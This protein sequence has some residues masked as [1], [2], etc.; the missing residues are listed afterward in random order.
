VLLSI[1]DLEP[2]RAYVEEE[3]VPL[4]PAPEAGLVRKLLRKGRSLARH[5]SRLPRLVFR[6]RRVASAVG[7]I[8][9]APPD[10][11]T[12][13]KGE[14]GVSKRIAWSGPIPL[15]QVKAIGCALGGTVNDVLLTAASGALRR[16]LQGH[17]ESADGI[18][19]H[20]AVPVN[21]RA[22]GTEGQLGNRVG[23][24]FAPLPVGVADPAARLRAVKCAMDRL[25]ESYQ[26]PV[27]FAGMQALGL[28]ATPLQRTAVGVLGG[29]ATAIMTNVVGPLERRYLAGAPVDA[30][31]FWVPKTG[32]LALGLSILSYAGQ[33]RLG[34]IT[35]QG[36]V[37]DPEAI[38]AGFEAEFEA[39]LAAAQEA[40]AAPTLQDLEARLDEARAM[41]ET[42]KARA[43][44]GNKPGGRG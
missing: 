37:S 31:L 41:L 23:T 32:G 18:T 13:F 17:G 24:V 10:P 5:P 44:A 43:A 21:L 39:L 19:L 1:T 27:T 7:Q 14:L 11:Q 29:R 12:A 30:L 33:V 34:V 40:R 26:A 35:D 42:L 3:K 16:Y 28:T 9:L 20:A 15:D 4:A 25:K 8:V 36:L 2:G 38:V 6:G 22:D